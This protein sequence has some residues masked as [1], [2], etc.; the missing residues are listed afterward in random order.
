LKLR[1]TSEGRRR[2]DGDT[3]SL[4]RRAALLRRLLWNDG[5]A[6]EY[7]TKNTGFANRQ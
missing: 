5:V 2:S 1:R 7:T 6:T 4:L 3:P